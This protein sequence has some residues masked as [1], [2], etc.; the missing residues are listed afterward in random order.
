MSGS[1]LS[2]ADVPQGEG[3]ILRSISLGAL[4]VIIIRLLLVLL[5]LSW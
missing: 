3:N 1:K 2:A 5:L 4:S